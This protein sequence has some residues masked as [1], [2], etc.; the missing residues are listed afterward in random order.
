LGSG[1]FIRYMVNTCGSQRAAS[2]GFVP[3][4]GKILEIAKSLAAK[5]G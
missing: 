4:E 1:E 2:L 5:A 3:L